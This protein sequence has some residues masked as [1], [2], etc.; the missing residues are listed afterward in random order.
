M[1]LR[2]VYIPMAEGPFRVKTRMVEFDWF[3]GMARSQKQKSIRS[4]HESARAQLGVNKLLEVSSKSEEPL[5]NALSAFNLMISSRSGELACSVECAYQAAKVFEHGGP[6]TDLLQ[7]SSVG[8]KKDSRLFNSGRLLHFKSNGQCWPLEPKSVYY[9]WLYVNALKRQPALCSATERFEAYTDIEF[10]PKRSL[11]CQAYSVAL[12]RA[13][14][15]RGELNSLTASPQAF[16]DAMRDGPV[17]DAK[18]DESVQPRF[19]W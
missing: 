19:R 5:G 16:L 10:N 7:T 12:Y 6:Y 1:A 8:A 4:L 9:D 15:W 14:V 18:D 2:P 13:L 17:S 11:N 3:A